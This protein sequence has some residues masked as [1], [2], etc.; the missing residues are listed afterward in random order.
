MSGG[1]PCKAGFDCTSSSTLW[2]LPWLAMTT[3]VASTEQPEVSFRMS[4]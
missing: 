1:M 3:P 4:A 2:P